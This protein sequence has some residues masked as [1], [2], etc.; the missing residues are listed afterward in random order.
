M[1]GEHTP[2]HLAS[3]DRARIQMDAVPAGHHAESALAMGFCH[4][5][6]AAIAAKAA[7]QVRGRPLVAA[8]GALPCF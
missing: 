2:C 7:Q 3:V 4:F 1:L 5:N 8:V 6:N